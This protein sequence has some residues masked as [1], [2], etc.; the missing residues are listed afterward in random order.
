MIISGP[1]ATLKQ[2]WESST[3]LAS[4]HV[5]LPV[6][7]P[8]HA[9]H[10]HRGVD[11]S[12]IMCS[13]D[14]RRSRTL[15]NYRLALPLISTSSGTS[16]DR[17][18][19]A[20]TVLA[21]VVNEILNEPLKL[22]DVI[23]GCQDLVAASHCC[24]CD[25]ISLGPNSSE[26]IFTKALDSETEADV[27]FHVNTPAQT[28]DGLGDINE[29]PRSSRKPKL[30]IVGMAG[31]FPNAADHEKFW[32]LLE[33]GL[34][35]HRKVRFLSLHGFLIRALIVPKI[36]ADRFNV[37]KHYDPT[38]KTRNTSHTP[39][40]NFIDEPGLFDP[41]FFNMSPREATVT[42]PM[43]R[44]GLASAY[45][46]LEMAGYVPN[47][48]PSTKL[49]RIGTFYGQTSDDWREIN[50]AQ[51]IDTYFITAGVRAFAPVSNSPEASLRFFLTEYQGEN[52]LLLQIQWPKFQHRYRMLLERSRVA[53]SMHVSVGWRLRY[54]GDWRS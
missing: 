13:S 48:S 6:H 2:L 5:E 45:E 44:L 33:A 4:N 54:G 3:V 32:D 49:D 12:Q 19:D 37:D 24:T 27:K 23:V 30:A 10:L 38:G 53:T 50:E 40:G 7:G 11:I 46:A 35:V 21:A 31:R 20:P 43:H 26:S 47:R 36:P 34:D 1:P 18:F 17:S 9:P 8:Y 16:F 25:I 51:D 42:D 15:A 14:T 28:P 29:A 52:Q 41:R 39:Y 22:R